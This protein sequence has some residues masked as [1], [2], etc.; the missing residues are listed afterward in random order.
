MSLFIIKFFFMRC[1]PA[2]FPGFPRLSKRASAVSLVML[3][4]GTGTGTGTG[5]RWLCDYSVL[6]NDAVSVVVVVVFFASSLLIG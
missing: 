4:Q 2:S 5:M 6:S 3:F 1:H